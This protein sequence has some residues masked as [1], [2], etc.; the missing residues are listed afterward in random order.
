[1]KRKKK[2]EKNKSEIKKLYVLI[3]L[4]EWTFDSKGMEEW[5]YY[6]KEME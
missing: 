6:W 1:M 4:Y 2:K 5:K 3:Q